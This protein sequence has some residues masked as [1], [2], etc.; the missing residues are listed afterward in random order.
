MLYHL[1]YRDQARLQ[2]APSLQ[3]T[4]LVRVLLKR[5]GLP[6]AP[7]RPAD[8][9]RT[10]YPSRQRT[11]YKNRWLEDEFQARVIQSTRESSEDVPRTLGR[12]SLQSAL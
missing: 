10:H 2:T 6:L 4:L 1:S 7:I 5:V 9:N 3:Q 11:I 12:T 8:R